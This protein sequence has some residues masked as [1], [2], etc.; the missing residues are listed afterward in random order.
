MNDK[1][2]IQKNFLT[3]MKLTE[4]LN[5]GLSLHQQ[6][7]ITEAQIFYRKI[8]KN[9]P[10]HIQALRL[11]GLI[12]AQRKQYDKAIVL[13]SRATKIDPNDPATFFNLSL[14]LQENKKIKDA[15]YFYNKTISLKPNYLEAHFNKGVALNLLVQFN[16]ALDSFNRAIELK[17]DYAEAYLNRGIS[18]QGLEQYNLAINSYDK[19]I[20]LKP[21]YAEAFINRGISL[22]GLEQ[23]NLA[24]NS[25][26]KAIEL[27]PDYAEAYLNRALSRQGLNQYDLA[28]DDYDKAIE[29][30]PDFAEAHFNKGVALQ[31]INQ[32][33]AA[34]NSYDNAIRVKPDFYIVYHQKSMLKLLLGEYEDGWRLYESRWKT[35]S[36]QDSFR[37]FNNPLWLGKQ[38]I[39]NK[40]ILIYAEQGLGDS[41]QFCRYIKMLE[42]LSP[43]KIF[44]EVPSAL[45]SILSTLD[46]KATLIDDSSSIA[47]FDFHCP[48]MSLPLALTT[49][50]N[51]IPAKIPYLYA[52]I[53]KVEHWANKLPKSK[54]PK[55]G[56]AWSGST[57]H[58]NDHNRS[59]SI[60]KLEPLLQLPFEFHCLQK[61]IRS[62]DL[63]IINE[64]KK[65]HTYQ[66]D[67]NDF[68]DTA[69]LIENLDLVISVDT[70]V[71]HLA[72]A[73]G[74]KVFIMLPYAPDYRWMLNRADSP[75]YPNASLFRQ[76]ER[77]DWESLIKHL[78]S[79]LINQF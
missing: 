50:L 53:N 41:I 28:F 15:I 24:I 72:G 13:L 31:D 7:Q 79:V 47:K 12:E 78:R 49:T 45:I 18:L 40:T 5:K 42:S 17:P 55:I 29:L 9:Y 26:D 68:S 48:L 6:G 65:I 23:Y 16:D 62:P 4:L 75:W 34:L 56:L 39:K 25:Y 32:F 43:K 54:Y 1:L 37:K 76:P 22:Q 8:L 46:S 38:S 30:K 64:L 63:K 69:A 27:K 3:Q 19:A 14:A 2:K 44:L 35:D 57:L 59:L 73:M 51:T 11:L 52:S 60:Q 67:L 33:S 71:A 21:D 20:E 74:K 70:S 61:E 58:K 66:E 36:L 77:G 10:S